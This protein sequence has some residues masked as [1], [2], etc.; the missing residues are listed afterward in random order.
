[1]TTAMEPTWRCSNCG[2]SLKAAEPPRICPMCRAQC[3][4]NDVSCYLP[5]CGGPKGADPRL[6]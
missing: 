4:F 2:F 3:E 1:M 5:E 6:K